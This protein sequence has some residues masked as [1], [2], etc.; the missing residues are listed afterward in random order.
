MTNLNLRDLYSKA[1]KSNKRLS[2]S[3]EMII[4]TDANYSHIYA[5][6]ICKGP[7]PLGEDAIK[8]QPFYSYL[9]CKD[10]I[11]QRW[12]DAED[13]IKKDPFCAYSYS[14]NI[15]QERWPEA[16]KCIKSNPVWAAAYAAEVIKGRWP[17]AEKRIA[18]DENASIDY[19][20]EVIRNNWKDWTEQEISTSPV[21]L[22]FYAKNIGDMLPKNLHEII[23]K[24]RGKYEIV[25][26]YLEFVYG[27]S[28]K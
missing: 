26:D 25:E 15:M 14:K 2:R 21:W 12:S 11:K 17:E 13:T 7:F 3:E 10:V 22:Y 27:R 18:K 9:Y 19:F 5:K 6:N 4:A 16:E 24:N 8:K 1:S 20:N 28:K 23:L